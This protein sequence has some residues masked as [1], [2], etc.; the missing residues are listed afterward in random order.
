MKGLR[1]STIALFLTCC[2]LMPMSAVGLVLCIGEDGHIA[3]EPVRNSR[4][5]T[6]I[7][8]PLTLS[9]Q[10]TP[11]T[12]SPDHC[13]PCVDVPLLTSD[14]A[15]QQF[16]PTFSFLLQLEMSGFTLV[17]W[18]VSASPE[19]PST[20]FWLSL[21]RVTNTTLSALRTVILLL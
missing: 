5:A 6:P 12:F 8:P 15:S 16:V 10:I 11:W 13:G 14:T 2:L 19:L 18:V 9:Q 17:P 21:P 1:S 20:P 3:L 4:C 7:A